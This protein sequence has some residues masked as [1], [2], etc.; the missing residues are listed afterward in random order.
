MVAV[1]AVIGVAVLGVTGSIGR[2][3]LD[4]LA[5]HPERYRLETAAAG[6]D[7]GGMLEV[8]RRFRPRRVALAEP[9]AA[10]RLRDG[11]GEAGLHRIEVLSGSEGVVDVGRDERV[12]TVV[13][14][15]VGAAGLASALAAAAAGKRIL[16][17][18]KEA[19]VVAGALFTRTAEAG[20]AR[21][22]PVDSEHNAVYQCL[23]RNDEDGLPWRDTADGVRQL[24]LTAS[25]GPFRDRDPASLA[26]VTP[27]EACAHPNWSMGRKISVD[28]ASMMNKGLEVIEAHHLF[29]MEPER[30]RVVIHRQSLMHALV[31]YR[32]GSMLA[33]MGAPDMRVPIAHALGHPHR[34]DS[35]VDLVDLAAAGR[36]DFEAPDPRRYPCLELAYRALEAGGGA[37]AVLNAANEV[38]VD[39]FLQGRLRFD[40]IA[41]VVDGALEKLAPP[42]PESLEAA[43]EIDA[44]GRWVAADIVQQ[45][46]C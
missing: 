7:V 25:G 34:I 11:L 27:E 10:R 3:T 45:S 2:S 20:D 18:N 19:L 46:I 40:R 35:G 5:R 32:D 29:G 30:I 26:A 13:A 1:G 15:I 43:L 24:I 4:L 28:S 21:I 8:C 38:A 12:E 14:A 9:E 37:C 22:L 41:A 36:L 39:A 23:S 16:L 42:A 6:R 17:A 44:A 31:C 33:H